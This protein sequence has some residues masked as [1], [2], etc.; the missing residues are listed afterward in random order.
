MAST[1][2][3]RCRFYRFKVTE[4]RHLP[5]SENPFLLKIL[6]NTELARSWLA[7]SRRYNESPVSGLRSGNI[8]HL[9]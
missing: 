4:T 2:C 9:G 1:V 3:N 7:K 8:D 5:F 6:R